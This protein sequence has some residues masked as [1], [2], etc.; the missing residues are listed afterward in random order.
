MSALLKWLEKKDP[1]LAKQWKAAMGGNDPTKLVELNDV[2]SLNEDVDTADI[3]RLIENVPWF[4]TAQ[5]TIYIDAD[6]LKEEN[7]ADYFN[8]QIEVDTI[9]DLLQDSDEVEVVFVKPENRD[10]SF[11]TGFF[12]VHNNKPAKSK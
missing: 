12:V 10:W 3:G 1:E 5:G 2:Y 4:V 6:V 7:E 11:R 9:D 8:Y